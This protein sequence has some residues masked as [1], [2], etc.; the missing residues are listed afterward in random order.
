MDYE[1]KTLLGHFSSYEREFYDL[2]RG[3]FLKYLFQIKIGG[4]E[5]AFISYHNT[6]KIFGFEF[7]KLEDMQRRIFGNS[8]FAD[9]IF[10]S[11]L[12][13]LEC[14]LDR[15]IHDFGSDSDVLKI[16]FFANEWKNTLDVFVE[17][18]FPESYK[19]THKYDYNN[20]I[21]YFYLSNYKPLVYKYSVSVFPIVNDMIHVFSPLLFEKFDNFG[22]RYKIF[23]QGK[24]SFDEYMKFIH[25]AYSSDILNLENQYSGSWSGF[26][27]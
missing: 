27:S 1:I 6:K 7:I 14:I 9:I 20:Y 8:N 11:S 4:M 13:L 3:A 10:K 26:F 25:E 24:V 18:I 21:D 19:D 17:I 15:I 23:F 2:I 5:G 22:C 16:G 12:R